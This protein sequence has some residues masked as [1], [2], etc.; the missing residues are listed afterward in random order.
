[1]IKNTYDISSIK[2]KILPLRERATIVSEWLKERLDK[3]LP[4]LMMNEEI[5]MWIVDGREYNEDPIMLSLLPSTMLSARRRTILIFTLR[6]DGSLEKLVLSRYGIEGFYEGVWN[7]E[8]EDQFSCLARMVEERNPKT[9]GLNFSENFQHADGLTYT[10]YNLLSKA[11]G[12]YME[13]VKSAERL[14]VRWLEKRIKPEIDAY[15]GI[16][17]IA[18]TIVREAFS[19]N[20]IHPRITTTEDVVWWIRQ[21]ILDLGLETWFQPTVDIQAPDNPPRNFG[22]SQEV[23]RKRI[24]PGDMIHCDVGI[25]YLNLCTDTQHNA[26]I[27]KL[28][29]KDALES[30]RNALKIT[31]RLQD[32]LLEEFEVGKTGNQILRS[33]LEKAFKEGI[34]GRIYTHP[35]GFHG[36]GAGPTIGLWDN[37]NEIPGRGDYEIVNDTCFSIELCTYHKIPEWG[38]MEIRLALE[39]DVV[40]T[41]NKPYWLHGRQEELYLIQ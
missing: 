41:N 2:K 12:G 6:R 21:T 32:I 19:S 15:P 38:G 31:N 18:H 9:I 35:L 7:P 17:E 5:D 10:E 25:R 33:A 3:L 34:K 14:A 4:E 28:G 39:D 23:G 1:M 29:E 40:F 22:V 16:V 30:L 37:Q 11:L 26:Y 8:K 20:V 27:L 24:I 36:H 13:R